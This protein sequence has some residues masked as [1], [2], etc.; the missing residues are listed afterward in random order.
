MP[1]SD[2][3]SAITTLPGAGSIGRDLQAEQR[4]RSSER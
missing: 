1:C 4:R 3:A 2:G